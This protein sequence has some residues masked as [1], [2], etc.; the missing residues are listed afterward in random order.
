MADATARPLLIAYDGSEHAR[1]AIVQAGA[2]LRPCEAV[3]ACVWAPLEP[4]APAATIAAPGGGAL[5]GA[6]KLDA[7]ARDRAERFALDGA[8]LARRAGL[9]ARSRA[10]RS[11]AA[12]WRAI[13]ELADELD[14]S[15]IVTGTR[16]RS[17][18]AAALLGSTAEGVLH[19]AA[20]SARGCSD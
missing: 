1:A 12:P 10:V 5:A 13:V 20:A 15:A 6:R 9:E 8:Q 3:V 18:A 11:D 17:R 16:G 14:A 4:A 7:K 2:L 19:H